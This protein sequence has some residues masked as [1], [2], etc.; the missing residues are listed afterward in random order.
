MSFERA[1]TKHGLILDTNLLILLLI[2]YYNAGYIEHCSKTQEYTEADFHYLANIIKALSPKIIVT[3]HILSELSNITF[4][5]MLS[6][7]KLKQYLQEVFALVELAAEQH[8]DKDI[9]ME[10]P[11]L[12]ADFGFTDLSI[13]EAAKQYSYAVM[14]A[15]DPLYAQLLQ[16]GCVAEN[17]KNARLLAAT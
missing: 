15:D 4:K 16:A 9:I 2:G 10:S 3:P 6:G 5:K 13:I 7:E 17:L 8:V 14:T 11:K 12:L 1:C